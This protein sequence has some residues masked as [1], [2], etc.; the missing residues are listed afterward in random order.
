MISG[1]NYVIY[2]CSSVGTTPGILRP[3]L[4]TGGKFCCSYCSRQGDW[5]ILKKANQEPNLG[6]Q[7]RSR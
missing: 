1:V 6:L 2:G 7:Q 5:W 3:A 4:N